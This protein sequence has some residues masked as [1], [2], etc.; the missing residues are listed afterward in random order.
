MLNLP[1]APARRS[2]HPDIPSPGQMLIG[3]FCRRRRAVAI[4]VS[5]VHPGKPLESFLFG[6]SCPGAKVSGWLGKHSIISSAT[7]SR[8]KSPTRTNSQPSSMAPV[9]VSTEQDSTTVALS[10]R[11]C[12]DRAPS[13]TRDL[14]H[15]MDNPSNHLPTQT[16]RL[17]DN[18]PRYHDNH[19]DNHL[20]F[21]PDKPT[22]NLGWIF[23]EYRTGTDGTNL[24]VGSCIVSAAVPAAGTKFCLAP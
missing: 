12:H 22:R 4:T 6:F 1:A 2:S 14:R 24:R 17:Q 5:T 9:V 13:V 7:T 23:I 8:L 19:N 21:A 15:L 16:H 10:A 11:G 18:K 20:D 3:G